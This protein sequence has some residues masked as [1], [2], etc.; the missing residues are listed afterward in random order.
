MK[1][2][3]LLTL[4]LISFC[5]AS[6]AG[7]GGKDF[8][9]GIILGEPTGITASWWA[10]SENTFTG[11][12]GA[13]YFGAPRIAVDYLWHFDA[14]NSQIVDMYAGPGGVI[15]FGE[16]KGFWYKSGKDNFYYRE[17]GSL[18]IGV[19]GVFGIDIYPKKVP[20]EIFAEIGVLVG[21]IDDFGAGADAA[22]GIRFYP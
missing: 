16:G 8:G 1:K 4:L 5:P 19:R 15:G 9:F 14:F 22:I 7:P 10:S 13:S 21:I 17:S 2:L 11:S 18:G 20:L 6:A 12:I 3:L